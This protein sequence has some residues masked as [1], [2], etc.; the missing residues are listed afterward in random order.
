LNPERHPPLATARQRDRRHLRAPHTS[1]HW[2]RAHT[3]P[4][5]GSRKFRKTMRVISAWSISALGKTKPFGR[6]TEQRQTRISAGQLG[7][8]T[9]SARQQFRL[10][11]IFVGLRR[12]TR[13]SFVVG[14][15]SKEK[16][17][18]TMRKL[19]AITQVTLDGVMQAPGGPEEDPRNGFA[20]G[21]WAM[22][23]GDDALNQA[24][25]EII[26]GEFDMTRADRAPTDEER[27]APLVDRCA[28]HAR[29]ADHDP[30]DL[31]QFIA[32]WK[33]RR[34]KRAGSN[35]GPFCRGLLHRGG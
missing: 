26:S 22:P 31:H 16:W 19:I 21:G 12:E 20:H 23:F 8:I 14:V 25:G 17:R 27:I 18:E 7:P 34:A 32:R 11:K 13:R 1:G 9:P 35:P 28:R 33:H 30:A 2:L 15:R 4:L 29:S 6:R 3:G 5:P 10:I 24:I